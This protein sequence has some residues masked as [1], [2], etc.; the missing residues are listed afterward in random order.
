MGL[1]VELTDVPRFAVLSPRSLYKTS[2]GNGG[3][4]TRAAGYVPM[5]TGGQA[6]GAI[7]YAIGGTS[8]LCT[9]GNGGTGDLP[10]I[11]AAYEATAQAVTG[12]VGGPDGGAGVRYKFPLL[13]R[14]VGPRI[15]AHPGVAAPS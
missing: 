4:T 9:Y 6:T 15:F 1:R 2:I 8:L 12:L 5:Q 10:V 11:T 7:T 13:R 14:G 3:T